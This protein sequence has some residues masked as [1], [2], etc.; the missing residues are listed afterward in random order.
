MSLFSKLFGGAGSPEPDAKPEMHKGF[1][2]TPTPIK[3]GARFRVSA[4]I[5]KEVDGVP[6]VHTLIRA[7][8]LDDLDGANQASIGKAKQVIDEQGDRIFG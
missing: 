5:E 4:R 2:I 7:D 8:V 6:K 3:E 1:S